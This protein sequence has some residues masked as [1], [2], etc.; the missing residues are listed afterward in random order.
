M[1]WQWLIFQLIL[2]RAANKWRIKKNHLSK[3]INV[4]QIPSIKLRKCLVVKLRED[5]HKIKVL[6]Q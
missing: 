5:N 3:S 2:L 1:S 6:I 4:Y